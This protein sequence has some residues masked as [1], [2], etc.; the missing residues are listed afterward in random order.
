MLWRYV[1]F[2]VMLYVK[3]VAL[4]ASASAAHFSGDVFRGSVLHTG[5]D[6]KL[7]CCLSVIFA[8]GL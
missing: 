6:E 3:S 7:R 5:G 4:A 2:E 8:M 1:V